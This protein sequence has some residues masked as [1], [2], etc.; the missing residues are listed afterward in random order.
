MED[1]SSTSYN[2]KTLTEFYSRERKARERANLDDVCSIYGTPR[3]SY[4]PV[5]GAQ[6]TLQATPNPCMERERQKTLNLP[7]ISLRTRGA[8]A[9]GGLVPDSRYQ[10]VNLNFG[11]PPHQV[12]HHHFGW[13]AAGFKPM[14]TQYSPRRPYGI[15]LAYGSSI[16]FRESPREAH[17]LPSPTG[18]GLSRLPGKPTTDSHQASSAGLSTMAPSDS[19]SIQST[20]K[21]DGNM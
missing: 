6:G 7:Q 1:L 10:E 9:A 16:N 11:F 20:S 3:R 21:S 14:A 4:R 17:R 12:H 2:H 5:L 8:D 15:G 18:R 13:T 19:L